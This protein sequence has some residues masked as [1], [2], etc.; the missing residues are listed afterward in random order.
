MAIAS[1]LKRHEGRAFPVLLLGETFGCTYCV[2]HERFSVNIFLQILSSR[3]FVL[4]ETLPRVRAH[5]LRHLASTFGRGTS[6]SRDF[7]RLKSWRLKP[8]SLG[9]ST[10]DCRSG[11][12]DDGG[13][14]SCSCLGQ[15]CCRIR[16]GEFLHRW[17]HQYRHGNK[18]RQIP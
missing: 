8:E 5:R 10:I 18:T 13:L 2:S 15:D 12:D 16:G 3:V 11:A 1:A 6:T 4:S 9:L 17:R 14:I 7:L